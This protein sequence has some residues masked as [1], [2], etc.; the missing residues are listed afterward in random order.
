M[1][2]DQLAHLQPGD[3][4]FAPVTPE[5]A[6]ACVVVRVDGRRVSLREEGSG[7]AIAREA[8]ELICRGRDVAAP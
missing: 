5:A 7:L 2:N 6:A 3:R 8:A 1:T 4:V